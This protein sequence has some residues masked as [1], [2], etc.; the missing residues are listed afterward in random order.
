MQMQRLLPMSFSFQLPVPGFILYPLP[1]ILPLITAPVEI[2]GYSQAGASPGAIGSRAILIEVDGGSSTTAGTGR[3][4]VDGLFRFTGT[5]DGSSLSG[6]AI[7]STGPSVEAI[8]IEPGGSDIHIWGNY[9]GLLAG[10]LSPAAAN[11]NGDDGVLIG[12]YQATSGAFSDIVIGTDGDGVNDANEG[13]V[14]SNSAD[15]TNGGDGVQIGRLGATYTYTSIRI[16]GNF[17]GLRADGITAAP[18][19]VNT[20]GVSPPN[21]SDGINA[22]SASNM[23]IGSNGDGI[24]DILERNVVS[25]NFCN[26]I[27]VSSGN[28]NRISGNYVSTDKNGD[29][30]HC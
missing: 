13:N 15:P 28:N 2:R 4:N 24:S 1:F 11:F 27:E 21:G 26:G 6:I 9:I 10:G 30:F 23:L 20:P 7:I 22:I 29:C 19:G 5:A 25:G 16:S 3:T 12:S 8:A 17:I 18:N 14:T